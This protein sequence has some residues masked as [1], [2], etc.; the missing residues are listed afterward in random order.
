MNNIKPMLLVAPEEH[1]D[2][3]IKPLIEKWDDEPT[4]LQILRVLDECT[5]GAHASPFVMNL[6]NT[7][8]ELAL[9]RE[10]KQYN[11]QDLLRFA[12]WRDR[13]W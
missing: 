1:L 7:L 12:L 5:Y 9:K 10:G 4:A 11:Y 8:L 13:D 6:L 2:A 3:C